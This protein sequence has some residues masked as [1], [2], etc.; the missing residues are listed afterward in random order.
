MSDEE[1]D[2]DELDALTAFLD[3]ED[4]RNPYDHEDDSDKGHKVPMATPKM[5]LDESKETE[6][7]LNDE[8]EEEDPSTD[9]SKSKEELIEEL[10]IMRKQL[11]E[12]KKSKS[13]GSQELF[14]Q[15][16]SGSLDSPTRKRLEK[17]RTGPAKNPS[18]KKNNPLP[19]ERRGS[20]PPKENGVQLK[21]SVS[22]GD[23]QFK[24]R[25]ENVKKEV[26]EKDIV[27]TAPIETQDVGENAVSGSSTKKSFSEIFG[28]LESSEKDAESNSKDD[29][30]K[31]HKDKDKGGIATECPKNDPASK[32]SFLEMFGSL[33]GSDDEADP[34]TS[35]GKEKVEKKSNSSANGKRREEEEEKSCSFAGGSNNFYQSSRQRV[36]HM[37]KHSPPKGSLST[38]K[39][40]QRKSIFSSIS[41]K[42]DKSQ[43]EPWEVEYYSKIRVSNPVVSMSALKVKMQQRKMLRLSILKR[44]VKGADVEGD[45]VTI[46]VIISKSSPKTSKTGK[47]F[48]IWKL[49]DLSR[50]CPLVSL[51]LFGKSHEDHWK[52]MEG[53]VVGLLN[54]KVMPPKDGSDDVSL[55]VDNP[56]KLLVLGK[57]KDMGWCKGS[58]KDGGRCTMFVNKSECEWCDYHIQSQYK[59]QCSKRTDLNTSYSGLNPTAAMKKA[60]QNVMYGGKLYNPT[61]R[62]KPIKNPNKKIAMKKLGSIY[63]NEIKEELKPKCVTLLGKDKL[64]EDTVVKVSGSTKQF[65]SL[66]SQPTPGS[67]NFIRHMV[68]AE[69]SQNFVS[70]AAADLLKEHQKKVSSLI[71]SRKRTKDGSVQR[72]RNKENSPV[73]PDDKEK[74]AKIKAKQDLLLEKFKKEFKSSQ[75]HKDTNKVEGGGG[76][77]LG[78][79]LTPGCDVDLSWERDSIKFNKTSHR[80]TR[81]ELAKAKA[82]ALVKRKG[83]L[84]KKD[85]NETQRTKRPLDERALVEIKKRTESNRKSSSDENVEEEQPTK[86]RRKV[87]LGE[88]IDIDSEEMKEIIAGK[89]EFKRQLEA[90]LEEK[91]FNEMEQKEKLELKMDSIMEK[92]V[93]VV[94]CQQCNFTWFCPSSL[95]KVENHKLKWHNAVQRFFKCEGCTLRSIAFFRYPTRHCRNCRGGKFTRVSMLNVR[96]KKE[97]TLL[98]RGEERKWIN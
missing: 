67:Q 53:T 35:D 79:D 58:K 55:S 2:F 83:Q 28:S 45:W 26:G 11:K 98:L 62:L 27:S 44:H 6:E 50:N 29:V 91:Y 78:S 30:E 77:V 90:E 65:H 3:E 36:A 12:S 87:V 71:N 21:H 70:V 10:R 63:A 89:S 64:E 52:T 51:F 20:E 48:S 39:D 42:T 16:L 97:G 56:Q 46:G 4:E 74:E 72:D 41:S 13:L 43:D 18:Q 25:T 23:C 33:E 8:E 76:P 75:K 24:A 82:L 60:T 9:E 14:S 31:G 54:A 7:E 95:C 15:A 32:K 17:K 69:R 94:S 92:E 93:K 84:A 85:P 38:P 96:E 80:M 37:P 49:N 57:S 88:V 47:Q 59:K 40:P 81:E 66:L 5:D 73:A 86:K 1:Y 68:E 19:L 61:E 22:N 34:P